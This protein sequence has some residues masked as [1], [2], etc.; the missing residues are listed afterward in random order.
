[1]A[2]RYASVVGALGSQ[3]DPA[4]LADASLIEEDR[5]LNRSDLVQ[6]LTA[7][8]QHPGWRVEPYVGPRATA[9]IND[10]V[11]WGIAPDSAVARGGY[12]HL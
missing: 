9:Y 3:N 8:V 1:L 11:S 6:W 5:A 10:L 12:V 2:D 4:L 7:N